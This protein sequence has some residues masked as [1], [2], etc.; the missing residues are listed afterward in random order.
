MVIAFS[1]LSGVEMK[2]AALRARLR[3]VRSLNARQ[4]SGAGEGS[5]IRRRRRKQE[6]MGTHL[7]AVRAFVKTE[8]DH[9]WRLPICVCRLA[10]DRYTTAY[11]QQRRA[12]HV[13]QIAKVFQSGNSQ[14]VRL[15]KS[16]R[17]DTDE[18]EISRE[19]DAVILRPHRGA[20]PAWASLR[21]A[22]ARGMSD[23]FL[24]DGRRQP[25]NADEPNL[26][27]LFD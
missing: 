8:L 9:W 19:G 20:K 15:P 27:E 6:N 26:D 1:G 21:A 24:A 14:A 18:V 5:G 16:F 3:D 13:T 4:R 17:F 7:R 10:H 2:K 11:I 23:D 25:E 22:L 12:C